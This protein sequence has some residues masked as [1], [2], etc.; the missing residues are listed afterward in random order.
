MVRES[1]NFWRLFT[2]F[3]S[4]PIN[5]FKP[6]WLRYK[7][8]VDNHPNLTPDLLTTPRTSN[9]LI[10]TDCLL[11]LPSLSHS[12][13]V[14]GFNKTPEGTRIDH[15]ATDGLHT[16]TNEAVSLTYSPFTGPFIPNV[17]EQAISRAGWSFPSIVFHF[18]RQFT[19]PSTYATAPHSQKKHFSKWHNYYRNCSDKA[20]SE[21]QKEKTRILLG[22]I[23]REVKDQNRRSSKT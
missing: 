20:E 5:I 9:P 8:K 11:G 19:C 2:L 14:V 6:D 3:C 15:Q 21:A 17:H 22:Y 23:I 13:V 18:P 12:P 10:T 4:F 1:Y 16:H 7:A